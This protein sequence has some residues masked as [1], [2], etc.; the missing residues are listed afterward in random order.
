MELMTHWGLYD[1]EHDCMPQEAG[2]EGTWLYEPDVSVDAYESY[3]QHIIVE[4]VRA[5]APY[6]LFYAHWQGLNPATGVGWDA[7][8]G[9]VER[10]QKHLWDRM[11]VVSQQVTDKGLLDQTVRI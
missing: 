7:F 1:F 3:F 6:C 5:R 8:T 4:L 11:V 10:V 9:V 2:H